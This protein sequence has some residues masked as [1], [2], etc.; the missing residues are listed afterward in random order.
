MKINFHKYHGTG[1]DFIIIDKE[2]NEIPPVEKIVEMCRRNFGIGADGVLVVSKSEIADYKMKIY[3][4]DGSIPEMCG[5]GIRCFV[6]Y[7]YDSDLIYEKVTV[8]TDAGIKSSTISLI[9]DKFFVEVEMGKSSFN[10]ETLFFK[11]YINEKLEELDKEITTVSMGNPHMV[12]FND[13]T[14]S[15]DEIEKIGDRYINSSIF[16]NQTNLEMVHINEDKTIDM[17]V[18]ERGVGVTLACGTGACAVGVAAIKKGFSFNKWI[19]IKL[20]GGDLFIKVRDDY[21]VIL[22]GEAKFVYSG[23][24]KI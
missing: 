14:T 1:N 4:S 23:M 8:E 10:D 24:I 15:R 3:N 7:L 21:S 19:K 12:I 17:M 13:F 18:F 5:N 2:K 9:D 11:S 6:K 22:K 20:L 16:K